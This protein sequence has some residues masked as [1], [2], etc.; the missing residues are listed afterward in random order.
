MT[1]LP[2]EKV[3]DRVHLN[4]KFENAGADNVNFKVTENQVIGSNCQSDIAA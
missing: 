4:G 3:S 1:S 2:P